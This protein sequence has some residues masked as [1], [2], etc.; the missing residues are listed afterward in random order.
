MN[1]IITPSVADRFG[2]AFKTTGTALDI[3][4]T[5]PVQA[6]NIASD[7]FTLGVRFHGLLKRIKDFGP[8]DAKEKALLP[9]L[10]TV[11]HELRTMGVKHI[12]PEVRLR[13]IH[14]LPNARCDMLLKGGLAPVGVVEVKVTSAVP[15]GPADAHLMQLAVYEELVARNHHQN[16]LW[17]C[18]AYVSFIQKQVRLFAYRDVTTIRRIACELLA[19]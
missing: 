17:G 2:T 15:D 6:S 3:V 10:N 4:R 1:T 5:S 7:N 11:R 8:L 19:A 12:D 9:Y 14:P 18:V 13:G 16:R